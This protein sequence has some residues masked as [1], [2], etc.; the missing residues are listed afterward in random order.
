MLKM[1]LNKEEIEFVSDAMLKYDAIEGITVNDIEVRV[2]GRYLNKE[3]KETA[4]GSSA[5]YRTNDIR[6]IYTHTHAQCVA[7]E[8][9]VNEIRNR[10]TLES[11]SAGEHSKNEGSKGTRVLTHEESME[12]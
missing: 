9:A 3:G 10:A 11:D 8:K 1:K 5:T 7:A 4:S 2:H 6:A 12:R